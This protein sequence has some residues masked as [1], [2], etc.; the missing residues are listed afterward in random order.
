MNAVIYAR[1][2]SDKQTE[3]S[4]EGQLRD[5]YSYAEKNNITIIGEYI[6]R[7][8]SGT[9]DSRPEFQRMITDSAKKQFSFVLVYKLD[10][11]ARNRYDSA[12]YKRKLRNNG[13]KVISVTEGIGDGDESIILEAVLEA[14]AEMYSK[15]LGQNVSRG[16]RESALKANSTGGIIPLGY[17]IEN[18]KLV[19]DEKTAPIVKYVFDAYASGVPK[20]KIAQELTA[21]GHLNRQGKPFTVNS[22][23]HILVNAKYIGTYHYNG[24]EVEGGCPALIDKEIFDKANRVL[25]MTKRA[26]AR[27]KAL[28]EYLL[29]GKLFCG[30]CG[31]NMVGES[32]RGKN[33]N[34]YNYYSCSKRK[35]EHACNKKN[36]KKDFL[37]WYV[38]EQTVEYVLAPERIEYIS[39]H[40][41]EKY[42]S[43]FNN[44]NI[45]ILEKRS[46]R[47]ERELNDCVDTLIKAKSQTMIAKVNERFEALEIQKNDID[48][49]LS[50]LRIAAKVKLTKDDIVTWLNGFCKGDPLEEDFRRRIID[51]F[52]NAVYLYDDKLVIYY[53]IEDGKQISYIDM[54]DSTSEA[55]LEFSDIKCNSSPN[56]LVS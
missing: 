34:I 2:S 33:S 40:V 42:N 15:Q 48:I 28:V 31:S 50:K 53:N 43:E 22:F 27:S 14:M 54:I 8:I 4:I 35:K 9:S 49:E 46:K 20:K 24:L 12:I 16:L 10:R 1:Y 18:K 39:E 37:E 32:G 17:K 30:Y 7:A 41:V 47:I 29:Y 55:E 56:D 52:I 25:S 38:V 36:E 11:F 51:V 44:D 21:Q 26:P 13:V 19:I 6:D 45:S 3:Q 23:R 5:C